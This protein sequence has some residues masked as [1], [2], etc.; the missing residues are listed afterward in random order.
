MIDSK[1]VDQNCKL[2]L[3][4]ICPTVMVLPLRDAMIFKKW[5]YQGTLGELESEAAVGPRQDITDDG[6]KCDISYLEIYPRS[7]DELNFQKT[8][9]PTKW[10]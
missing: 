5:N 8:A 1:H 4:F 7:L 6:R 3:F 9:L 10:P 2:F